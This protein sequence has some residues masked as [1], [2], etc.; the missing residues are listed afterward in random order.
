[1]NK[2]IEKQPLTYHAYPAIRNA[3]LGHANASFL[4]DQQSSRINVLT[5]QALIQ[6]HGLTMIKWGDEYKQWDTTVDIG[7]FTVLSQ[8]YLTLQDDNIVHH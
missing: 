3:C 7:Y 1:M 2:L 4:H 5:T 6:Y 8:P